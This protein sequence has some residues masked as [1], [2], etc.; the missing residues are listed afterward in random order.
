MAPPYEWEKDNPEGHLAELI[1]CFKVLSLV[2]EFEL[3]TGLDR[4]L[5]SCP[6]FLY[7][8]QFDERILKIY[9]KTTKT[10]NI[11]VKKKHPIYQE[12]VYHQ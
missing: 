12:L 6:T 8:Y 4:L 7:I 5:F 1:T 9:T 10:S 2:E 3:K 11:P